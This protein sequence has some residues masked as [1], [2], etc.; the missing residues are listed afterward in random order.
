MRGR[1]WAI[2]RAL[3]A[4]RLRLRETAPHAFTTY[5]RRTPEKRLVDDQSS[6]ARNALTRSMSGCLS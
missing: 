2:A 4:E 5:Y 1:Q 3:L 6:R